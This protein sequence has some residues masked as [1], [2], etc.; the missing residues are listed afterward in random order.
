MECFL[1][2]SSR[3]TPLS[4]CS[5]MVIKAC[6]TTCPL[7]YESLTIRQYG[8]EDAFSCAGG[9]AIFLVPGVVT[10]WHGDE[11][12]KAPPPRHAPLTAAGSSGPCLP[13]PPLL[14]APPASPNLR[15]LSTSLTAASLRRGNYLAPFA[16]PPPFVTDLEMP[17]HDRGFPVLLPLT[18]SLDAG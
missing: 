2:L 8:P 17:K 7:I 13:C 10:H 6:N 18:D 4:S 5:A 3:Q 1:H 9:C 16:P 15:L 14:P 12:W 11:Q